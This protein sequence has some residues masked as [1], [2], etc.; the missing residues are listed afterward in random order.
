MTTKVTGNLAQ[1]TLAMCTSI[2]LS[3]LVRYVLSSLDV[4]A[5]LLL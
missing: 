1:D 2:P 4:I 5:L 3:L